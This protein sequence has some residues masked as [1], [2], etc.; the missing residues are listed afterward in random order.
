MIY[1]SHTPSAVPIFEA[2]TFVPLGGAIQ[3]SHDFSFYRHRTTGP[4]PDSIQ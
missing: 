4:V 2:R 3:I 1:L